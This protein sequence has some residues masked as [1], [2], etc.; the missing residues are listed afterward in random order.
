[1]V[2]DDLAPELLL[3]ILCQIDTPKDLHSLISASPHCYRLFASSQ[4]HVISCV[5]RNAF[6]IENI[7]H[8]VGALSLPAAHE[9]IRPNNAEITSALDR[10]FDGDTLDLPE[11]KAS[12][13]ALCRL[14]HRVNQYTSDYFQ[15]S[16]YVLG[17]VPNCAADF[18]P[19][20]RERTRFYRGFLRL[21]LFC[22]AFYDRAYPD[23]PE[24]GNSKQIQFDDFI[25]RL[26]PWEVEE[27]SCALCYL[28][29]V[30]EGVVDAVEDYL[31]KALLTNPAAYI[32]PPG[33]APPMA[34]TNTDIPDEGYLVYCDGLEREGLEL[35]SESG[36][37]LA[38]ERI[39]SLAALGL[40]F[41][42]HLVKSDND[43]RYLIIQRRSKRGL[44]LPDTLDSAPSTDAEIRTPDKFNNI[45]VDRPNLGW[46]WFKARE[47]HIYSGWHP[48]YDNW[49]LRERAFVF[50]DPRRIRNLKGLYAQFPNARKGRVDG[51]YA[52]WSRSSLE[53]RLSNIW[54]PKI[55]MNEILHGSAELPLDE[56][57]Y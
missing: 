30:V 38:P 48:T 1:M 51:V 40:G 14:Y 24:P 56:E 16:L 8:A 57:D 18:Y 19:S 2:L 6:R 42:H 49:R 17:Y 47:Q 31:Y 25:S 3:L 20:I 27:I 7:H 11:D 32:V 21:E 28:V 5:L 45:R 33:E 15:H 13:V 39:I 43:K 35:F 22:R 53:E 23:D 55:L 52:R 9:R 41:V 34:L 37:Y 46:F 4:E 10:Y 26:E 44:F 12:L 50:W 36:R 54:V 29:F